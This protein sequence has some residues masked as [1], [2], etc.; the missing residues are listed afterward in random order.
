M[1]KE[2]LYFPIELRESENGGPGV[3]RG[4]LLPFE[5]KATDRSELF[6]NGSVTWPSGGLVLNQQHDRTKALA[7][8]EPESRDGGLWVDAKLSDTAQ[9]RDA[10]TLI[11][12]GVLTGMSIEF[13]AQAE[14]REAGVRVILAATLSGGALVDNSSYPTT[15]SVRERSHRRRIPWL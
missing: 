1:A 3:I 8:F 11:R 2:T 10:A 14:T 4:L 6:R 12:D 9:A 5:T 7:R 13:S 15:V